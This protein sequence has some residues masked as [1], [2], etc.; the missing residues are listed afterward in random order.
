MVDSE[1]VP[2]LG[3]RLHLLG[4]LKLPQ[5]ASTDEVNSTDG[6]N[7]VNSTDGSIEVPGSFDPV[8]PLYPCDHLG[9]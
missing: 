4:V 9:S 3:F 5:D 6:S 7:E 8:R 1:K 2:T